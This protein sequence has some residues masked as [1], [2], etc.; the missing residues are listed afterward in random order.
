MIKSVRQPYFKM[1]LWLAMM[2]AASGATKADIK[3]V[4]REKG[5]AAWEK[6]I[7]EHWRRMQEILSTEPKTVTVPLYL[8]PGESAPS[9]QNV[10]RNYQ[11]LLQDDKHAVAIAMLS[12]GKGD[13]ATGYMDYKLWYRVSLDGGRSYGVEKP[14]I[15]QGAEFS[16]MHPNRF[17]WV[18]TNSF[19]YAAI[20]PFLP[21]SNGQF[22]I[23]FYYAPLDAN[24]KY[25]NPLHAY[26]FSWVA[27]LIGTWNQRH[28]DIIWQ[29]SQNVRLEADQS[30]RGA[31][32]CAVIELKK[33]GHLLMVTRG[34]NEPD[35]KGNLPACKW[36]TVSTDYGQ[37]WSPYTPLTYRDG[38]EFFSPSSCSSLF[39]SERTGKVYWIGNISQTKPKG[40]R[41]RY[42]L[43]I[44]ELD[45]KTLGLKKETVTII[46]DFKPG[47]RAG[48]QLSNFE[49][50]E[51]PK[52]GRVVIKLNRLSPPP[53]AATDDAGVHTYVIQLK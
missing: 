44:A 17:V 13:T 34:S 16:A 23:P 36:K 33:R 6:V 38:Q 46:D 37:T 5:D 1:M 31:G 47:D 27:V 40:S 4:S 43:V 45:E 8:Y 15:E 49:W 12:R 3:V 50:V 48:M 32:E 41:P 29:V 18:G 51:E 20:P 24:G 52:T 9:K 21:L 30:A 28:D 10:Y 39:R 25:Y 22:I 19:C 14:V 53:A 35:P 26:T 7:P 42:P 2:L 11:T